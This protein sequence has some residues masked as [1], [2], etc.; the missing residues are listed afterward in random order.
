MVDVTVNGERRSLQEGTTLNLLVGELGL[1][2]K[3]VVCE[4]NISIVSRK[5][6]GTTVLSPG[7][8]VEIIGFVGGG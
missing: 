3:P 2:E 5:D 4:V 8:V 1:E 7:D 6:W